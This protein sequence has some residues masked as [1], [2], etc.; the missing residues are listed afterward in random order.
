MTEIPDILLF[1]RRVGPLHAE[2]MASIALHTQ[3]S[4]NVICVFEEDTT[5]FQA[6]NLALARSKSRFAVIM[7]DDAIPMT[8][9]WLGILVEVLRKHDDIA[10]V[11]P[12]EVKSPEDRQKY[13]EDPNLIFPADLPSIVWRNWTAGYVLAIDR[14]K[15]PDIHADEELA[16]RYGM[17]DTDMCL[18]ATHAGYK[19]CIT[20]KVCVYHPWKHLDRE[21]REKYGMEQ[22]EDELPMHRLHVAH[23]EK[24]W[25]QFYRDNYG[26]KTLGVVED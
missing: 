21:W 15:V 3:Q 1:M 7:D 16:G 24:K 23:M 17:S 8:V 14:E 11:A 26:L 22:A 2:Q 19:V 9:G 18:Q 12:V 6:V 5:A 10:I 20:T 25:G 13:L 4:Y